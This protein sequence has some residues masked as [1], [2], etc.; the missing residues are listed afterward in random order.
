M[1]APVQRPP[2]QQAVGVVK[3]RLA[4][5]RTDDQVSR[6]FNEWREVAGDAKCGWLICGRGEEGTGDLEDKDEG[7]VAEGHGRRVD[8]LGGGRLFG[9]WLDLVGGGKGR[10]DAVEEDVDEGREPP[11]EEL[12]E[13]TADN[14]NDMRVVACDNV[15]PHL[16]HR[17][18]RY[19]VVADLT[20]TTSERDL[21]ESADGSTCRTDLEIFKKNIS[22][23][24]SAANK[25]TM[26]LSNELN[27]WRR[28]PLVCGEPGPSHFK[29]GPDF[30]LARMEA[31]AGSVVGLLFCKRVSHFWPFSFQSTGEII[32]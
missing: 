5:E 13:L 28:A 10:C 21:N 18:W 11:E 2:V 31:V 19:Q 26:E 14:V 20:P 6:N 29:V 27:W 30:R 15:P 16:F 8:D 22:R 23:R 3:E 12:D 1:Y 24:F 17:I 4:G 25:G 9:R 7:L 32:S